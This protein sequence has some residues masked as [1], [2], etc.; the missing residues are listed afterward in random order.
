MKVQDLESSIW[1]ELKAPS[2]A[3][4]AELQRSNQVARPAADAP[5]GIQSQQGLLQALRSVFPGL[6]QGASGVLKAPGL[7]LLF[8]WFFPS[9]LLANS[10][11]VRKAF[12]ASLFSSL[13]S[14]QSPL[15][16][17]S[18]H[19]QGQGSFF[20]LGQPSLHA[21][22]VLLLVHTSQHGGQTSSLFFYL[23]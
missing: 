1:K 10:R 3:G 14:Q 7:Y 23:F 21:H 6:V 15:S 11:T 4:A 5:P 9:N 18:S 19:A 20:L 22:E 13:W 17:H 2:L 16:A 8:S 12:S